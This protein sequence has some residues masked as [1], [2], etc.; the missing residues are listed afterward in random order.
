MM[1]PTTNWR[2]VVD[3]D[4]IVKNKTALEIVELR[5]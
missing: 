4:R 5:K 1:Y 3:A 2:G